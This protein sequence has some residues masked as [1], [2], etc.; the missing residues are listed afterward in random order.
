VL[1]GVSARGKRRG[2]FDGLAQKATERGKNY[3]V[4]TRDYHKRQQDRG[5]MMV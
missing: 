2:V 4:S 1:E 3:G 5:R